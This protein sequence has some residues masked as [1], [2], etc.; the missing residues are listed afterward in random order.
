M[1]ARVFVIVIFICLMLPPAKYVIAAPLAQDA[2]TA[3]Q[4][5]DSLPIGVFW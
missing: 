3:P 2:L 5:A 4:K 1:F